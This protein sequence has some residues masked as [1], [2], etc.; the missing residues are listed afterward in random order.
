M[1]R[2]VAVI[3]FLSER[4]LP[5]R[6]NDEL[7]R[8]AHN[9]NYLGILEL[10]AQFDP[11][12]KDHLQ[13]FGQKGRGRTSYLS[14]TICEEFIGLMGDRTKEAIA[15]ELQR[16]RYFSV[17]VDST[18]DMSH[19][20]QLTFV[21]R[22]VSE[23]GKVIERF[24]GFEPIHSHTGSSLADCVMKMV[25]DMGLDLSNCRGQAHDKASNMSGKYNGQ[26]AH[27]K[28]SNPL[29]HYIPCAAH[30]LNLVGVNCVE[31]SCREASFLIYF[32]HFMRFA[33]LL[34]TDGIK[35]SLKTSH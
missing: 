19:V 8:S 34:P 6:G 7:L 23:K 29:I 28:K 35:C 30:S 13:K 10:L 15:T 21:F 22:F 33:L 11:F 18:P 16:A 5:F 14:S 26:Q 27:L 20:D 24:I 25:I 31:N 1:R 32:K 9:G 12:L 4:G 17:I 3:K 2:V